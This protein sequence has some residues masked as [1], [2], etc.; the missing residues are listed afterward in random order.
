MN[1][2]YQALAMKLLEKNPNVA[3]NPR[4]AEMIKVLQSG[5]EQQ[6]IELANN[7]LSTYGIS[8]EDGVK[9]GLQYFGLG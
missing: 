5:N 1:I 9:R 7:I 2:N 6:G 4:S 3:N 8:K